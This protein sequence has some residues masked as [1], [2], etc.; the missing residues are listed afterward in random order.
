MLL[1]YVAQQLVDPALPD[2]TGALLHGEEGGVVEQVARTGLD[3]AEEIPEA[4]STADVVRVEPGGP[5]EVVAGFVVAGFIV[6]V[7]RRRSAVKFDR[8]RH[9]LHE[10]GTGQ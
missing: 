10:V 8:L 7:T 5:A 2:S 3:S 1:R 6:A 4:G 9:P